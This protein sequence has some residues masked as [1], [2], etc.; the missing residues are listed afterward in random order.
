VQKESRIEEGHPTPDQVHMMIAIPA[1]ICSVR[2][3]WVTSKAGARFTWRGSMESGSE[4][5][6]GTTFCTRGY[7]VPTVGRDEAVIRDYIRNQEREDERLE[8]MDP[9]R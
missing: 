3:R 8:Q 7:F 1:E 5:S 4:T 9:A 2:T 6:W